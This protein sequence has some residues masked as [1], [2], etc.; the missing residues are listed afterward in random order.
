MNFLGV[1]PFELFLILII[2][3]VVLGPERLAQAGR[4]LGRL[5]ARYRLR[6]QKDV[7][8][9]TR[10]FRQELTAMQK[11]LEEVRQTTEDEIRTT[12][13]ALQ[14]TIDTT[15]STGAVIPEIHLPDKR[16]G[17]ARTQAVEDSD[18]ADGIDAR[19]RSRWQKDMEE[20]DPGLRQQLAMLRQGLENVRQTAEGAMKTARAALEI[21]TASEA[22]G[23]AEGA[24]EG[25]AGEAQTAAGDDSVQGGTGSLEGSAPSREPPVNETE[26]DEVE[27]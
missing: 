5:Y 25:G 6:W 20:M 7:D 4:T 22:G 26:T 24:D 21:A 9:L 27:G 13:A 10:E 2:A 19:Y 14:S 1:G 15:A 16:D 3:T 12:Q 11:E 18:A 8:E 23:D 17:V